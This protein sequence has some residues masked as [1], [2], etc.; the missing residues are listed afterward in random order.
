MIRKSPFMKNSYFYYK[1]YI[2]FLLVFFWRTIVFWFGGGENGDVL[3]YATLAGVE[4][5][6]LNLILTSPKY[7][8]QKSR[9]P[10]LCLL[11]ELTML[12]V[13]VFNQA[14]LSHY[15]KCFA[16][17]LFFESSYLF[18]RWNYHLLNRFRRVFYILTLLGGIY[19][20]F[21]LQLKDFESQTNMVYFAMLTVPYLLLTQNTKWRY[22]ILIFA[23]FAA[24]ISMKRSMM[25]AIVLFW[26][27][28]AVKSLLSK[29][30]KTLAFFVVIL[31]LVA[32]YGSYKVVDRLTEGHLSARTIDYEKDDISNGREAIYMVT[33][34]M[35]KSTSPI[36]L[37]LGNGH[38]AVRRDSI[39][40]ISAHNEILEIIYDYGLIMLLIYVFF[41]IYIVRQW[42]YHSRN[43]TIYFV[44]YT[45]S[46][47]VFAVMAMVSQLVLYVSY[48]LYLVM[49]WGMVGAARDIQEN[50]RKNSYKIKT[51]TKRKRI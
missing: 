44:P 6:S 31:M 40:D 7:R 24:F 23:T 12:I 8:Y 20:V 3:L 28:F 16:W 1:I 10:I 34:E 32:L 47:C 43:H 46:V 38:N 22:Y 13:L 37:L 26:G 48:F 11:W 36:H 35:I 30:K 51:S 21:A 33:I 2:V 41:W 9:I 39:L 25:L 18:I 49:F 17:P 5:M 4:L 19:F 29:G 14:P 15:F 45:F 27:I 42:L 50:V